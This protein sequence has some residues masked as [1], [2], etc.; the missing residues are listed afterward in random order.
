MSYFS[1]KDYNFIRFIKAKAKHKKYTAILQNKKN[2]KIIKLNFGD[3]RH[4]QYKDTTGLNIY[5]NKNHLDNKRRDNY[6]KRHSVYIKKGYYS[7][8]YFSMKFLWDFNI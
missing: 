6:K 7:P 8:S 4:E 5:T 2:K 1:K 3:N